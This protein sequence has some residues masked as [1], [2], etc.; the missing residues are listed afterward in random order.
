MLSLSEGVGVAE[1]TER[2]NSVGSSDHQLGSRPIGRLLARQPT[3]IQKAG[4]S[5]SSSRTASASRNWPFV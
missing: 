3:P 2:A 5:V 1:I 4:L